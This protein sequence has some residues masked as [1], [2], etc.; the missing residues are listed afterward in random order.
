MNVCEGERRR[1]YRPRC[2]ALLERTV[3]DAGQEDL[4]ECARLLALNLAHHPTE[5]GHG[6]GRQLLR[7]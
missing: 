3:K 2:D 1:L 4:A 6:Q 7:I 5:S